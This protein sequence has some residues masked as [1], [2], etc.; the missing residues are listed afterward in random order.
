[1]ILITGNDGIIPE[2]ILNSGFPVTTTLKILGFEITKNFLDF[3][4]VIDKLNT[5]V[6][7]GTGSA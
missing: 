4:K 3:D 6:R 7:F 2:Y 1:M 5:T